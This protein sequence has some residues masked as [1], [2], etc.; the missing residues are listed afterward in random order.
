MKHWRF[1]IC[2]SLVLGACL[3][4]CAEPARTTRLT[5]ADFQEMAGLMAESLMR[6]EALA[7]RGP[8]S[9]PW[10]VSMERMQNLSSDVM[11]ES[12]QW[13]I[14]ARLRNA[15]PL[16]QLWHDKNVRFV[17]PPE[18]ARELRES[19]ALAAEPMAP[20]RRAPTHT[21]SATIRSV[22]RATARARSDLYYCEFE[23]LEL[24]TGEPVWSDR[25]EIQREALGHVW[26]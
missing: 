15:T 26:N 19:E 2:G 17:L 10:V 1:W 14:M 20:G 13:L 18:R 5:V 8:E 21:L 7:A 23:V 25:F 6:S 22:T 24:E 3:A 9:E 4:G 12:E 11:T 16:A